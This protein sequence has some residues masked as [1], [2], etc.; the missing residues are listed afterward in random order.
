[1]VKLRFMSLWCMHGI[2]RTI[3]TN[4]T[5]VTI[6]VRSTLHQKLILEKADSNQ[7]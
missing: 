6:Y 2:E 5:F 7:C 1:M 3:L 4:R